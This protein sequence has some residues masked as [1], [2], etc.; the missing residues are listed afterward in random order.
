MEYGQQNS[1]NPC[2]G[3]RL[4]AMH[5]RAYDQGR[6]TVLPDFTIRVTEHL[7]RPELDLFAQSTLAQCHGQAIHLPERFRP[8]PAFL[9]EQ[10][11]RLEFL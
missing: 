9:E 6:I 11:R 1:L 4:S 5:Y 7:R 3:L 10:A 2:N 8:A